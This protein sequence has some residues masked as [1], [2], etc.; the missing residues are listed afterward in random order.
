MVLQYKIEEIFLIQQ[1]R[2]CQ[3]LTTMPIQ[4]STSKMGLDPDQD[5]W[6]KNPKIR[7]ITNPNLKQFCNGDRIIPE[8]N[9]LKALK[10]Q[11]AGR[12]TGYYL[13]MHRLR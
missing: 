6:V 1:L 2:I 9:G 4:L 5:H 11:Q 7:A 10:W 13:K 3:N 12:A 8:F